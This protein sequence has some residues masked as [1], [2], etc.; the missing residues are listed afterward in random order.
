ML[1]NGKQSQKYVRIYFIVIK[2]HLCHRL[3][4]SKCLSARKETELSVLFQHKSLKV[5]TWIS[6]AE[7]CLTGN[8]M[9]GFL[10]DA[11]LALCVDQPISALIHLPALHCNLS[12]HRCRCFLELKRHFCL[13]PQLMISGTE[14]VCWRTQHSIHWERIYQIVAIIDPRLW[15]D[16]SLTTVPAKVFSKTFPNQQWARY[17]STQVNVVLLS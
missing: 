8:A 11:V 1:G 13:P 16:V 7:T 9:G 5:A 6:Q 4:L 14:A 12:A 15:I 2:G 10:R 17:N 3:S